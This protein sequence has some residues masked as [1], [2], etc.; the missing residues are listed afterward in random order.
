VAFGAALRAGSHGDRDDVVLVRGRSVAISGEPV[1][2][3]ADGEVH[4]GWTE[5]TWWIDPGAWSIVV[6]PG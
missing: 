6:P 3:D 5:Q 4:E 2:I 1:D